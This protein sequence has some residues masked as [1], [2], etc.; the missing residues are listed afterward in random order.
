M[1]VST[2]L[3]ER[4]CS[5]SCWM[6]RRI[7]DDKGVETVVGDGTGDKRKSVVMG[8]VTCK[9][10]SSVDVVTVFLIITLSCSTVVLLDSSS[11]TLMTVSAE[12]SGS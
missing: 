3:S 1:F 12:S 9:L 7:G 11:R 8:M 10:S 4:F 5:W 2:G 6:I